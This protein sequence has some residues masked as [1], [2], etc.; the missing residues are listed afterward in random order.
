MLRVNLVYSYSHSNNSA[1]SLPP[2]WHLSICSIV[3]YNII[4]YIKLSP[5]CKTFSYIKRGMVW[6]LYTQC[7]VIRT[8]KNSAFLYNASYRSTEEAECDQLF[9]EVYLSDMFYD[10]LLCDW[11]C[12]ISPNKHDKKTCATRSARKC[13][14]MSPTFSN[15]GNTWEQHSTLCNILYQSE[16][17]IK[18]NGLSEDSIQQGPYSPYKLCY[19]CLYIGNI[20]FPHVDNTQST[21]HN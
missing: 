14:V 3:C 8:S 5:C 13:A 15:M 21:G 20:F 4:K 12:S 1:R 18:F 17:K 6:G 11:L 19:H 10:W 9:K 2:F 16:W 7:K